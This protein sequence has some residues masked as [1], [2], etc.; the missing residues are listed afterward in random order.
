MGT[1]VFRSSE[2]PFLTKKELN[3][4]P[5]DLFFCDKS[6]YFKFAVSR[7]SKTTKDGEGLEDV[8]TLEELAEWQENQKKIEAIKAEGGQVPEKVIYKGNVYKYYDPQEERVTKDGRNVVKPFKKLN[9]SELTNLMYQIG[10][11]IMPPRDT[12]DFRYK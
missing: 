11:T 10:V 8:K 9:E 3:E 5:E 4:S 6:R 7:T 1:F 2:L 12:D